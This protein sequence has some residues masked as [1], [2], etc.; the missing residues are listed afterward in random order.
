MSCG[1]RK[2]KDGSWSCNKKRNV[3]SERKKYK[4]LK[5]RMSEIC[6][7]LNYKKNRSLRGKCVLKRKR[8]SGRRESTRRGWKGKGLRWRNSARKKPKIFFTNKELQTKKL[9]F[10]FK[11]IDENKKNCWKKRDCLRK[12]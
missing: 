4:G 2:E 5:N 1:G 11:L 10:Y 8:W 7:C 6:V 9:K 12:K 3:G